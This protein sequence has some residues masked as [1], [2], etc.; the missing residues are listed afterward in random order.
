MKKEIDKGFCGRGF[1]T[2]E[3]DIIQEIVES[4][5]RLSRTELANTDFVWEFP[6]S[7][8]GTKNMVMLPWKSFRLTERG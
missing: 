1:T 6:F 2:E 4:C 8:E 7:R 3:L 5:H